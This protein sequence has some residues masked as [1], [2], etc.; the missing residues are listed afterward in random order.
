MGIGATFEQRIK[1]VGWAPVAFWS[2]KLSD[3]E[4]RYS[5]TD[6]EWLAV[7]EAVTRQWR[8]WLK[9][10]KFVLRSDHGALRQLLTTKGEYYS[11]RQHRWAEKLQ[12]YH[13]EFQHIPGPTNTAA[14]ALSRAL[15]YYVSALELGRVAR[16]NRQLG[17][18]R[19]V[20]AVKGD[21]GYQEALKEAREG[22]GHWKEGEGGVLVDGEGR[23]RLLRNAELRF[24]IIL[25]AHE[26]A[27]CG[28]LGAK[29]TAEAVS[30]A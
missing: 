10:R 30:R 23:V 9:G 15:S 22:R 21:V 16:D 4:K 25:E 24:L 12:D 29:R 28:H 17:W 26:P 18:W 13:F 2:R 6:Q 27:F 19:V 14:D 1:G 5:A 11:N 7:V 8:H 20:E 3:A